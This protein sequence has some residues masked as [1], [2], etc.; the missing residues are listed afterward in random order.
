MRH[1]LKRC[2]QHENSDHDKNRVGYF[3]YQHPHIHLYLGSVSNGNNTPR[4]AAEYSAS[5]T[6][7]FF[8]A[9]GFRKSDLVGLECLTIKKPAG[10]IQFG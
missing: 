5:R 2:Q 1:G 6:S 4:Q 8:I 7:P 10:D 3:I 9:A